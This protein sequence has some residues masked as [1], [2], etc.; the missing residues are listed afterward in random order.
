MFCC[1]WSL[2][3]RFVVAIRC[4]FPM[5]VTWLVLFRSIVQACRTPDLER[6]FV[7]ASTAIIDVFHFQ[8][9]VERETAALASLSINV[10]TVANTNAMASAVPGAS[11]PDDVI[12]A[13]AAAEE[14]EDIDSDDDDD[15]DS[16]GAVGTAASE[17]NIGPDGIPRPGRNRKGLSAIDSLSKVVLPILG[18]LLTTKSASGTVTGVRKNDGDNVAL[19]P[20]A[21]LAYVKVLLL[22]PETMFN[23]LFPRFLLR[24]CAALKSRLQS[25][26]DAA[27]QTLVQIS[28]TVGH[29]H[30]NTILLEARRTLHSGFAVHVLGHVFH[31]LLLGAA[32]HIVPKVTA[33]VPV[34]SRRSDND[35]DEGLEE[36]G[37]GSEV[38]LQ[39]LPL[40]LEVIMEDV[41]GTVAETR[42]SD[43]GYNPKVCGGTR[44]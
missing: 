20:F 21:S 38:L 22:L 25:E 16:N 19:K 36:V 10:A 28:A 32:S 11:I 12:A 7:R 41:L 14:A 6:V 44:P 8:E 9:L 37:E 27:K 34:T 33:P 40:L 5:S 42:Q 13:A 2:C 35:G 1:C 4:L 15:D 39:C 17:A 26:R 30:L 31:A 24:A 29:K 3:T 18:R 43:S 23:V